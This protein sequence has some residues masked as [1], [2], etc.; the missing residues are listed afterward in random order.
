MLTEIRDR[1]SGVFAWV[2]AALIIIP[3]AFWGVQEYAST[4]AQPTI[5][6]IG[7]QKITQQGF[8]IQLA[9]AQARAAEQNPGLANSDIFS[10]DFYK[11]QV[12]DGMIERAVAEDLA[13]QHN[14]QIGDKQLAELIKQSPIFQTDGKFDKSAF[15]AYAVSQGYSK[16]QFE[17]NTRAN[18]RVSQVASGYEESALVLP[19]EIRSLL[20]IQ[21]EQRSFDLI[22]INKSDY[23]EGIEVSEADIAAHYSDKQDQYME[24]DRISI[25]YVEI[26]LD[27]IAEGVT[28]SADKVQEIYDDNVE[29]Y[30]SPETRETRHILL[31]TTSGEDD[32]AQLAKAQEIFDQLSNGADFAELALAN[33]QDPGSK[34]NGGSL[35]EVEIGTMVPEF[36]EAAFAL[37]EGA[38]SQPVKSQFGYHI[39]RVDKILGGVAQSFDEVKFDIEQEERDRI[40]EDRLLENVEQ[41]RNVVFEQPGS[42]DG[43]AALLNLEVRETELF[44][45]ESGQGIAS[46]ES[47]RAAAFSELVS[48]DGLNSEPIE[49]SDGVYVALRKL[50][51]V[52]SAPKA[53]ETVSAQIKSSLLDSRA[54]EAAKLA[55]D[56]VLQKAE[57]SWNELANDESLEIA[58][59]TISMIA[60]DDN[61]APDVLR[62][63]LKIQLG[64]AATK[65]TSFTGSNGDF[66]IVRLNKIAPGNVAAVSE[67]IKESTRRLI[68]QRNGSSLFQSYLKG[69]SEDLNDE[70]N[71]ELL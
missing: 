28:V 58:S 13:V 1:S 24:A 29:S 19:D 37:A 49:L 59:H 51:F 39:I 4:E 33:S 60:N 36:E 32:D 27:Q 18:T 41:L 69:L 65:V 15:E 54:S 7:D 35:G 5:I 52:A 68:A 26:S 57:L 46:N 22:K 63:V 47:I 20:E 23:I 2:I 53:L 16:T 17:Q 70:I 44:S 40:A 21:S 50:S 67:Q 66:N 62:E 9:N 6:E 64:D 8:Q 42:L 12:L 71:Q 25:S 48:V 11:R 31:S 14:Y 34:N 38:I 56:S 3:M 43:A 30:I 45:R 55:G 61:V 10:S